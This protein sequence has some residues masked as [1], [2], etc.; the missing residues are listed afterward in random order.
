MVLLKVRSNL[1][2]GVSYERA[3]P[4]KQIDQDTIE[5]TGSAYSLIGIYNRI[6]ECEDLGIVECSMKRDDLIPDFVVN[7]IDRFIR[8]CG[9]CIVKD[10]SSYTI[11]FHRIR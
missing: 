6:M 7:P 10:L 4:M 9:T 3:C 11:Q 5:F 8:E 2:S 1:L